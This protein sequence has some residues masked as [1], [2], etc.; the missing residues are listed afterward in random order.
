VGFSVK[1]TREARRR[2]A[3]AVIVAS[4]ACLA[5]ASCDLFVGS[6]DRLNRAEELLAKGSYAEAMVEIHNA[7]ADEPANARGQLLYARAAL[8]LGNLEAA[9]KALDQAEAAK[10][11]AADV[12][13][14]RA[15]ILLGHARYADLLAALDAKSLS[16]DGS[17]DRAL[18]IQ[19]LAALGRCNEAVQLSR[20]PALDASQQAARLARADCF[21]RH[22][23]PSLALRELEAAA[24]VSKNDA[25]T[26]MALGRLRQLTG[27]TRGAEEAWKTASRFAPGQLSVPQ[28][29]TIYA[30]LADLQLARGEIDS[31][32]ATHQK[33]VELAPQSALTELMGARVKLLT[34]ADADA[35][36]ALRQLMTRAPN[37]NG[38]RVLLASAYLK[39]GNIEQA[40][41][42]LAWLE[43]NVPDAG[44]I[45]GALT[46]ANNLAK[47]TP[48]TEEYLMSLAVAQASLGQPDAA[49]AALAQVQKL[50]PGSS[51]AAVFQALLSLR[52]MDPEAALRHVEPFA[53]KEPPIPV[54]RAMYG[55]ALAADKR[56]DEAATVFGKL[57]DSHPSAAYSVALFQARKEG[58]LADPAASLERW[59]AKN[60]KDNA[61][62]ALY[63]EHL[64]SLDD[65]AH[66]IAQY[67]ILLESD[68][69]NAAALN[70]LAWLY[71]LEG[72]RRALPLAERAWQVAPQVSAIAD[73]YGWLLVEANSVEQ[74]LG[75]LAKTDAAYGF[76]QPEIRYH[77]AV[78]L[79]RAGKRDEAVQLLRGLL[80]D[81]PAFDSH[82]QATRLLAEMQ[83]PGAT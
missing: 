59:L 58:G 16:L 78:A 27:D 70:N 49:R 45:K 4:A 64:R 50:A 25:E 68:S 63:A 74:G 34:G 30:S 24:E 3:I 33:L 79:S 22:G 17:A 5:L 37:L 6:Q 77:Y 20:E 71:Y 8:Q 60:P 62:R 44:D 1:Q 72:D 23:N 11:P 40:R 66:A 52:A 41:Q 36:N 14:L 2:H 83:N 57:E 13:P 47:Q 12:G 42:E 32:R 55:Q 18:R 76:A 67:E 35:V 65:R 29:A 80:A 7:G 61:V 81:A 51:R 82:E 73:T 53:K 10:A 21:A 46:Q 54:A 31:V 9:Q 56:F 43:Q 69:R 26:W 19:A 38:A 39:Q 75:I 48:G 15:K 28:Q